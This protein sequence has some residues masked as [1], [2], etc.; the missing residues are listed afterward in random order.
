MYSLIIIDDEI[1]IRNGLA[2]FFDW[3]SLGFEVLQTFGSPVDA[4]DYMGKRRVDAALTDV[5]MPS[6]SGLDFA[7]RVLDNELATR[8]VFLSGYKEFDFIKKAMEYKAVDYLLKPASAKE[9]D[10]VFSS[11]RKTLDQERKPSALNPGTEP[12]DRQAARFRQLKLYIEENYSTTNLEDAAGFMKMNPYYLSK[13]FKKMAGE[14]FL[15]YLTRLRME[16]AQHL[17]QKV[18]LTINQI[19][20][21]VGY[22]NPNNFSRAFKKYYGKS[23]G[24]YAHDE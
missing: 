24:S 16:K 18:G 7:K 1:E 5:R 8:I 6:M 14:G 19:G 9:I 20:T 13:Y 12:E 23:P 4:L 21:I 17:I 15:D 3:E 10:R 22:T 11:L 2:N